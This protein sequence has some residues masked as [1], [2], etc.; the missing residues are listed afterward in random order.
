M[1]YIVYETENKINGMKYRG[2]HFADNLEDGYLGSGVYFKRALSTYGR[3][4]F[5][6]RIICLCDSIED[7]I[8][9]EAEYVDENWVSRNDT[10]NLQTGGLNYGVLCEASKQKISESVSNSHKTGKYDYSNLK[11]KTPWNKGKTGI[12]SQEQLD[13]WSSERK[14]NEPWNKGLTGVQDAWNKGIEMGPMPEEEKKK[15]SI[16]LKK[17]YETQEHHLKGKDPWNKGIKTGTSSWNSGLT[18]EKTIQCP[19]CGTFGASMGNMKRWHFDKCR[20]K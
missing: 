17:R 12:Y 15:R 19:H 8:R 1:F 3:E 10:Y 14:G 11:G 16:A 18:L 7:M 13:K 20:Q 2:C 6:R 5:E 4:N 9:K